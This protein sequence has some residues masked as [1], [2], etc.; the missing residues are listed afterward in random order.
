MTEWV[1]NSLM[2]LDQEETKERF[3]EIDAGEFFN[4]NKF[5]NNG[6][7]DKDGSITWSEYIQEAFG[8]NAEDSEKILT[9]PDDQKVL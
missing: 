7:T 8:M 9:D 2:T 1:R 3:D 6:L 4:N 5:K